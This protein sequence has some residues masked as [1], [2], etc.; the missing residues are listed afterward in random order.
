L[1][2]LFYGLNLS[3]NGL[4]SD[5]HSEIGKLGMLISL[6]I[7]LNN[8]TGYADPLGGLVSLSEV[9]ISY[10][11]FFRR[12]LL[13]SPP[14][15]FM[16]NPLLCVTLSC[17]K[18]DYLN[19]TVSE[20]TRK[21]SKV[22]I[23]LIELGS[24]IFISAILLIIIRM[25]HHR[26][27]LKRAS[28]LKQIFF[29]VR[30]EESL[31]FT[32]DSDYELKISTEKAMS[33]LQEQVLE[34]TE[35]LKDEYI[36]GRGAHGIV[37]KAIIDQQVC[38]VKKLEFGRNKQKRLSIM[39]NEIKVLR[40]I[41]HRSLIKYSGYWIG[42]DYG[43]VLF[44]FI[45]NGSLHDILHEK[46]PPPLLTWN[47]RCKIAAG[48]AQGLA[49]LHYDCVLPILH[50]DLKPKNILVND[51]MEP[52]IAD[53]GTALCKKL[54]EDSNS[55]SETRKMLLPHVVGTPGYIAPGN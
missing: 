17:N 53:F 29:N 54:F 25:Y 27:E 9:N 8:F 46:K 34:A 15:S 12:R 44:E 48:I 43:L 40:I 52:I 6:D 51:N 37:Y 7:S 32:N 30:G 41:K 23:V 49:Y 42:E 50:R 13:N 55:Y 39:R 1:Q 4:I 47:V 21:V 19:Q 3:A 45:E 11:L 22:G 18:T 35:N 2:N 26:K 5:I 28:D 24:S 31:E 10:K 33:S 38:A 20:G 16:G 14:S 36:I